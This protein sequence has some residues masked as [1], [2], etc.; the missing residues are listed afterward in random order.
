MRVLIYFTLLLSTIIANAQNQ[1]LNFSFGHTKNISCV[2]FSNDGK[3]ALSASIDKTIKLWELATG[4][5]IKTFYGL[6]SVVNKIAFFPKS[7]QFIVGFNTSE[8]QIIDIESKNLIKK[9][10][11]SEI[12]TQQIVNIDVAENEKSILIAYMNECKIWNLETNSIDFSNKGTEKFILNARFLPQSNSK[13]IVSFKNS[14]N[15]AK[16]EIVDT[17]SNLIESINIENQTITNL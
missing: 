2:R 15:E 9:L 16:L 14:K 4:K 6:N 7:N 11:A 13:F 1:D 8:V 3:F 5:E 17:K 10:D 12:E